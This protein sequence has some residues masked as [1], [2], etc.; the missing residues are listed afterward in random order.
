MYFDIQ[1]QFYD[2]MPTVILAQS[3]GCHVTSSVGGLLVLVPA[4][5][6][7]YYY[8]MSKATA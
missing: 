7:T 1:Q 5:P 2:L 6:G 8:G 4:L 3:T